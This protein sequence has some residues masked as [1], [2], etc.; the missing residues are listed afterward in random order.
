MVLKTL[1]LM[2][3]VMVN[4]LDGEG[5][6]AWSSATFECSEPASVVWLPLLSFAFFARLLFFPF[7]MMWIRNTT[8]N[9]M[10]EALELFGQVGG[11]CCELKQRSD[12]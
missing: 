9:A 5:L 2:F 1:T 8:S 7:A 11:C 12:R 3:L 4:F 6:G 10:F